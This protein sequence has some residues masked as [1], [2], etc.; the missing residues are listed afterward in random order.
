MIR[1]MRM[2]GYDPDRTGTFGIVT[3]TADQFVFA[4]NNPDNP[5]N[6]LTLS[7]DLYSPSYTDT[8]ALGRRADAGARSAIAEN[9]EELEFLYVLADGTPKLTPTAAQLADIRSVQV[10]ILARARFPDRNYTHNQFY[11]PASNPLVQNTGDCLD[12]DGTKWKPAND[13]IRRRFQVMTVQ[14]RNMGL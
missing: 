9:I 12:P 3:A 13:H 10:S 4:L 6:A 7:Y 11:C 14:L 1:D 2:A 8:D 5:G